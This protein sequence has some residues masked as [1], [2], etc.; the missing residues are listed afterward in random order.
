ML[1]IFQRFCWSG[2]ILFAVDR[3]CLH[4]DFQLRRTNCLCGSKKPRCV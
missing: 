4:A 1:G 3:L 2:H